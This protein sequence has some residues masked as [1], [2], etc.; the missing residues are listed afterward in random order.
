MFITLGK[1]G[2]LCFVV[3]VGRLFQGKGVWDTNRA[4]WCRPTLAGKGWLNW[5]QVEP[6]RK[7]PCSPCG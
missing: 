7:R 3:S 5:R 2:L 4:G 1:V 6:S